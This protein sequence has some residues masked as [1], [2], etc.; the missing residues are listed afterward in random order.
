MVNLYARS[1][2]VVFLIIPYRYYISVDYIN[3]Y[4][5]LESLNIRFSKIM[6]VANSTEDNESPENT[7]DRIKFPGIIKTNKNMHPL[8]GASI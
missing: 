5:L 3:C 1:F 2:T 7:K 8:P 4:P 6:L